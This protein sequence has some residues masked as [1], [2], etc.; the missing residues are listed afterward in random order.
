MRRG[1]WIRNRV[2]SGRCGSQ[3]IHPGTWSS[4]PLCYLEDLFVATEVRGNGTGTALI[5]AIH[6]E[7]QRNDWSK[8][9]WVTKPNNPA[10]A[11][12][13]R[14]AVLDDFVRYSIKM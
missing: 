10:R 4:Q 13:D 8:I 9:Y 2:D 14:I 11:L 7:A 3:S 6:D 1:R 5:K 12:Y